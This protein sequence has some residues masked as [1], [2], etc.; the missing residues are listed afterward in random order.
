MKRPDPME[1]STWDEILDTQLSETRRREFHARRQAVLS[2]GS[3][4][5]VKAA[6]KKFG[7]S[8]DTLSS[9]IIKALEIAPDGRPWG[10]RAC[11][12][13]R[14]RT[15][16]P[17]AQVDPPHKAAPNAFSKLLAARPKLEQL[18]VQYT[19][20]LPERYKPAPGF[21]RLFTAWKAHA[22][23]LVPADRYPCNAPDFARRSCIGFIKR[24]REGAP[25]IDPSFEV[26]DQVDVA[27]LAEVFEL[28][29]TAWT[30]YDGHA[31][32]CEFYMEG[33]DPH[34][35]TFLQKITKV[36]LLIGFAATARLAVSWRLSFAANYS[37]VDFN[38]VCG[39]GL[40]DWEPRDLLAPSMRYVPGSG[41]GTG[42]AIGFTAVGCVT[43]CDNAMAHR[44]RVNRQQMA[45]QL[46]GVIHFGCAHVPETRGLLEA[47]NKR[48]A[49]CMIRQLP[50]G[51]R[52]GAAEGLSTRTSKEHARDYPVVLEALRDLADVVI[53]GYN[54][55]A[56]AQHQERSPLEYVRDQFARGAWFINATRQADRARRLSRE[57]VTVTIVGNRRTKR[58]PYV[59]FKYARYRAPSLKGRWDLL[60]ESYNAEYDINDLRYLHLYDANGELFVVLRALRPWASTPH[61]LD[62]R[63]IVHRCNRQGKFEI[64]GGADAI[65]SYRDYLRTIFPESRHA[66][67]ELARFQSAFDSI[68]PNSVLT[69]LPESTPTPS[70]KAE[71]LFVPLS[72]PISL[73]KRRPS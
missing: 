64:R 52:P 73:G 40:Q 63:K 2:V 43:S 68:P 54:A 53:S 61:D 55:T 38:L 4:L 32:D 10:W 1:M 21:E 12:P 56:I 67:T 24:E 39:G 66:A 8:A 31:K 59:R 13:Y 71:R 17:V 69:P 9:T 72:G 28:P 22:R 34:G 41:I 36:W 37:G 6:S 7:V 50:G 18:L 30:Q 25:Y 46:L 16:S 19:G 44:L 33:T 11:V 20:P 35:K 3:G 45:E 5:T 26:A 14:V 27:Q 48:L 60:G 47:F 70:G 62:L 29:V 49:E 65:A 58:Q 23:E 57:R 42:A 15:K 51:Y